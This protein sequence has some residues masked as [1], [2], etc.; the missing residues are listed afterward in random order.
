MYLHV[1]KWTSGNLIYFAV[2]YYVIGSL[3][4]EETSLKFLGKEAEFARS[5]LDKQHEFNGTS[6]EVNKI[7]QSFY[8]GRHAQQKFA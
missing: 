8:V 5:L 7:R 4:K 2:V 6:L 3:Q 1:Q